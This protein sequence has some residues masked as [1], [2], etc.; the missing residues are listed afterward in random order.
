MLLL[1]PILV[2]QMILLAVGFGMVISSVTTKYRDLAML[3]SFGLDLWRYASPIA[4]GLE[5]VP[6]RYFGLYLLN[7]M[8]SILT[9]FRYSVFGFGYLNLYY[10]LISWLLTIFFFILGLILFSHIE[11]T[12][13][14]TI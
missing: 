5:L 14:D 12:F 11:R 1:I 2:L 7:P 4:Y 8:V 10:F 3:V 6:D 13:M 9:T